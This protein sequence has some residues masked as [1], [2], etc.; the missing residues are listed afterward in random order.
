MG[1]TTYKVATRA[2]KLA[3]RQTEQAV[4]LLKQHYTE[5]TFEIHK[6]S[7]KGDRRQER[8]LSQFG[9]QGVFVKEIEQ[10]LLNG[11]MDFA[12]H[13]L[14]DVP[15]KVDQDLELCAFPR[16]E[17]PNDL[18]L[19]R[20]GS[21]IHTIRE[22]FVVGTGSPRRQVQIRRIR[23]DAHCKDIRGNIDTRLSKL[24]HDDYDAIVLAAA[25]FKRAGRQYDSSHI[26]P[27]DVSLPAIGQGVLALQCRKSDGQL[28]NLLQAVNHK[29][30]ELEI[31]AERKFMKELGGGCQ[32]PV[33]AYAKINGSVMNIEGLI[34]DRSM[35]R[36]I[37]MKVSGPPEQG[38]EIAK[39]LAGEMLD[40]CENE[41]IQF[42]A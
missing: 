42:Q 33:A 20:D 9:G 35:K 12:V 22:G 23:P 25:G 7:T 3:Y 38:E 28:I 32:I 36:S 4:N 8:S 26:M 31:M 16:R 5:A 41:N 34:G 19:T 6:I 37:R 2:S 30:T 39:K 14:K 10:A 1:K 24:E 18:F 40:R 13:S 17:I 29:E 11:E 27:V 21:T 15:T